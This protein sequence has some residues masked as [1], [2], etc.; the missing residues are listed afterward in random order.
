MRITHRPV[1]LSEAISR[2]ARWS[3]LWKTKQSAFDLCRW[4]AIVVL[5]SH[6]LRDCNWYIDCPSFTFHSDEWFTLVPFPFWA[7]PLLV[8][9]SHCNLPE[10]D[11]AQEFS[12]FSNV[13]RLRIV[14][15]D[16]DLMQHLGHLVSNALNTK[17][18]RLHSKGFRYISQA[19]SVTAAIF[20]FLQL[21][22]SCQ[23]WGSERNHQR[24][25]SS[26]CQDLCTNV[27]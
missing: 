10:N 23:I 19:R 16:S 18:C 14:L 15:Y 22:F 9:L 7:L 8:S 13:A 12:G 24:M 2:L 1:V 3:S 21:V 6:F 25:L 11:Q 5:V 20:E 27:N 17:L 26:A 4:S